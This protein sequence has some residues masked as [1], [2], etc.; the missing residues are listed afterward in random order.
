MREACGGSSSGAAG[1]GVGT[2]RGSLFFHVWACL[3]VVSGW[4]CVMVLPATAMRKQ[5]DEYGAHG[6]VR[7]SLGVLSVFMLLCWSGSRRGRLTQPLGTASPRTCMQCRTAL[8]HLHVCVAWLRQ[9][10]GPLSLL[11][12]PCA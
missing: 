11:C 8:M 5:Q 3:V 7:L 2:L 12:R 4:L 1:G 9:G 6:C 10:T